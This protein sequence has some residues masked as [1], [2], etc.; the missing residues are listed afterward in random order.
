MDKG[1]IKDGFWDK[2]EVKI[3]TKPK[4]PQ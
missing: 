3:N 2:L 1:W 4:S